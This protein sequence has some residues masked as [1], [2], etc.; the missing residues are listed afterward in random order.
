MIG[1]YVTGIMGVLGLLVSLAWIAH[2]GLYILPVVPVSGML[3]AAFVE[4]DNAFS[5]LGVFAFAAFCLYLMGGSRA[6][7]TV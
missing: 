3:N 4:L 7:K 2:I 1:F 5:L 6:Q